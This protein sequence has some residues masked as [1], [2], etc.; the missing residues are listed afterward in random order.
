MNLKKQDKNENERKSS[1]I[2]KVIKGSLISIFIS[3]ILLFIASL[4]L[5]YTNI[6]ENAIPTMIIIISAISIFIGSL[7]SAMHIKQKGILN[8]SLV[9]AIY[10][11]IIYL[12]S[13]IAIT[14]FNMNIKSLIMLAASII[15]GTIG[16][17]VG[18][19]L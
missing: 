10:I 8:G 16:G 1:N 11:I 15:A 12:F 5:T 6:G 19:N 3:V 17:I 2:L 9:G 4:I 7:V 14:G 18:V 13:S